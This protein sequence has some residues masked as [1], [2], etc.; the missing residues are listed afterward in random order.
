MKRLML[1]PV[2]LLAAAAVPVQEKKEMT[3]KEQVA[4]AA[5]YALPKGWEET[6]AR[7]QG[8]AQAV[9]KR[10]LHRIAVRLSGGEGSKYR[11]AADFVVGLEARSAL[12][13]PPEKA[14]SVLVSG[15]RVMLYK[16]KVAVDMPLPGTGG[17]STY[18]EEEFLV[19]PAGAGFFVLSYRYEDSVPD[20][21][22]DGRKAWR[23]FLKTFKLKKTA[24]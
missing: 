11:K 2:L 23:D 19:L 5:S 18:T 16:R 9:L 4:A 13:K 10:D 22:Y 8:D 6:F 7:N 3:P 14:G 17:P 1:I 12:G 20:P 21:S 15:R 24:K